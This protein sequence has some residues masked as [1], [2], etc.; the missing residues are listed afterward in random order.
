MRIDPVTPIAAALR[1]LTD[2]EIARRVVAGETEMFELLMRRHNQRLFR[3][4]RGAVDNDAEAED[5]LQDAWVRAFEHL[6]E[7]RG[8]ARLS[9][10]LARI[11]LHEAWARLRRGKRFVE[12]L[13]EDDPAAPRHQGPDPEQRAFSAELRASLERAVAAM[14]RAA[15]AVFMLREVEGL[16]TEQTAELLGLTPGAVKVRLH[17]A[18]A[19]LRADLDRRLGSAARELFRFDGARCDRTV[20]NVLVRVSDA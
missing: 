18:R 12:L 7:F 19:G 2:E 8:E 4:V 16:T 1:E 15:R 10:W 20:R 9:T 17:R 3:V 11:A 13:P 5:V 14:P 6:G